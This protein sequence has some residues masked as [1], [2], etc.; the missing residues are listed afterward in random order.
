MPEEHPT[1]EPTRSFGYRFARYTVL[2]ELA[3]KVAEA[4]EEQFLLRDAIGP[5][6]DRF[7][8][9]EQQAV[10]VPK[11]SAEGDNSMATIIRFFVALLVKEQDLYEPLGRGYYRAHTDRD[12]SDDALAEAG[13][14][15][16]DEDA[17][18]YE[19]WIYAFSFPAIIR[20]DGPF[21]IKIGKTIS[22][23]EARVAEQVRGSATF[24][25]PRILDRW[26][27]KR[28]G[29]TELAIHNTL[30]ARDKWR[31]NVPG[32]EW[33]DTTIDEIRAI[34]IFINAGAS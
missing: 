13:I 17:E 5:I 21:P 34:V 26:R 23:V 1:F 18:E 9:Q 32:R 24:E 3:K 22:D 28:V 12:F 16:G 30:K 2:P 27:V 31:E 11:R 19:G 8:T 6:I 25:H 7:L 10:R 33:F 15:V 14:E 20:V 4:R 29:P